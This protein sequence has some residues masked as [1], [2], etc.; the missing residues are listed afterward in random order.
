MTTK[1]IFNRLRKVSGYPCVSLLLPTHRTAPENYQDA[2]VLKN[3]ANEARE[4]LLREFE[5]REVNFILDNLQSVQESID[6]QV[7]KEGMGIFISDGV[8]EVVRVP[9]SVGQPH[10]V[11]DHNFATRPVIRAMNSNSTYYILTLSES[12]IRLFEA[13]RDRSHEVFEN[14]FPVANKHHHVTHKMR[15]VW[16]KEEDERMRDFFREVD[17][18]FDE[19]YKS[20]PRRLVLAGSEHALDNFRHVTSHGKLILASVVGNYDNSPAGSLGEIVWPDVEAANRRLQL[21]AMDQLGEA[22]GSN[23]VAMGLSE[24]YAT[25]IQGQ[26][27][28]LFVEENFFHPAKVVGGHLDVMVNREDPEVVDDIVDEIAETVLAMKGKV[29]FVDEGMLQNFGTPIAMTLRY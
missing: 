25:A 10:V 9:V 5:E 12:S 21:E 26:G 2:K 24:V 4:R 15:T 8:C 7:N 29:V 27:D 13:S 11:I 6:H 20:H 16:T 1:E 22:R 19:V 3:L 23:K 18:K 14:G 28:T 17:A